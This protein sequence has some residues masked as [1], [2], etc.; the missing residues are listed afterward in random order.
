MCINII[1]DRSKY[2]YRMLERMGWCEGR[3]LG[4]NEDGQTEHLKVVA[5]RDNTG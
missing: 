4:L 1:V 3:G 5:K 2:G